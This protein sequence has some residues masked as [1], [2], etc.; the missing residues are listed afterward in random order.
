MWLFHLQNRFLIANMIV[1]LG[2]TQVPQ[3]PAQRKSS[4]SQQALHRRSAFQLSSDREFLA[5][6]E[7]RGSLVVK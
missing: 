2:T 3:K 7:S 4:L 5:I 1:M 6:V